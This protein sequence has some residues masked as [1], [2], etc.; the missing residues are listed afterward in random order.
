MAS[1]IILALVTA[2]AGVMLGVYFR[3]CFA[4]SRDDRV[5]G[6]IRFNARTQSVRSARTVIGFKRF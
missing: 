5:K 4:L 3:I 2:A 1:L 6:T